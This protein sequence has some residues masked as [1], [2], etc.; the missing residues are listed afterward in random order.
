MAGL[1]CGT[2]SP[3]A[4]PILHSGI[5]AFV[6]VDDTDAEDAMRALAEVGVE[7][8]ESGAAGLAGLLAFGPELG[9]TRSDRV[10]VISTEGA[11][12]PVA[13]AR[14]VG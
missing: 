3:I 7:S 10:L 11:T 14:I 8:G 13:Y 9:L 2:P 4:W 5:S 6:T 1:N 12:D